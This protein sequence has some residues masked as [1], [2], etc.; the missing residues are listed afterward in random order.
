MSKIRTLYEKLS[1]HLI[2]SP[3]SI[4]MDTFDTIDAIYNQEFDIVDA[5][6]PFVNLLECTATHSAAAQNAANML[7]RRQYPMLAES[8]E[9]LFYHMSD[10]DHLDR[11]VIPVK[12]VKIWVAVPADQIRQY[13]VLDPMIGLKKVTLPADTQLTVDGYDFFLHW[14]VDIVVS[15]SDQLSARYDLSFTTP[16]SSRTSN[17]IE[18][19]TGHLQKQEYFFLYLEVD[20]LKVVS[21]KK[22]IS[23]ATG[24]SITTGYSD[25]FYYARVFSSVDGKVWSELKTTHTDQV[26]DPLVPTA[27]IQVGTGVVTVKIPEIYLSNNIVRGNM[28]IDIFT[29]RGKLKINFADYTESQWAV[30]WNDFG[31]LTRTWSEPLGKFSSFFVYGVERYAGGSD[32]LTFEQMKQKVVY[33]LYSKPAPFT[34]GELR[35]FLDAKNYRVSKQK[36]NIFGRVYVASSALPLPE[37]RD[38]SSSIGLINAPIEI[39][40]SRTDIVDSLKI[41]DG[42]VA[43]K[44]NVLFKGVS[45]G[46][47]LM[48]KTETENLDNLSLRAKSEELT[49]G[50][51]YYS[52]FHYILD[53]TEPAFNARAYYLPACREIARSYIANNNTLG[54]IVN[55]IKTEIIFNNADN[56]YQVLIDTQIPGN[57][58]NIHAVINYRDPTTGYNWD[59]IGVRS[60]VDSKTYRYAFDLTTELDI[61]KNHNF[62]MLGFTGPNDNKV[63]LNLLN[64]TFDLIYVIDGVGTSPFDSYLA[65]KALTQPVIGVV[66][67]RLIIRWGKHLDKLYIKSRPLITE[68]VY[69]RYTSDQQ[70]YYLEDI[71]EEGIAGNVLIPDGQGGLTYNFIHRAGDPM[72]EADGV[73]PVWLHRAGDII[74]D[75]VTDQPKVK[76]DSYIKHEVRFMLFDAAFYF[77]DTDEIVSYRNTIPD[78]ILEV[79]ESDIRNVQPAAAEETEIYYE[80]ISSSTSARVRIIEGREAVYRTAL[81][82]RL[83]VALNESAYGNAGIR[84]NIEK[85][86]R[87]KIAE[88]SESREITMLDVY[89]KMRQVAT[90]DIRN[91]TVESPFSNSD[92]AMLLDDNAKWS[93]A[94]QVVPLANGRLD[95]VDAIDIEW[96]K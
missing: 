2:V 1:G 4:A 57:N 24:A 84:E 52:M 58:E 13:A 47:R 62:T 19:R 80:P 78:Y 15:N 64:T 95:I 94:S 41:N 90:T 18:T 26:F 93:I 69:E 17:V 68:P 36:D 3:A 37:K 33:N 91:I 48:T 85:L 89:D 11:F 42:L 60:K 44:P 73:T 70:A 7:T 27:L 20:Q 10:M 51:Y 79:L 32:G 53:D 40:A 43:V 87:S 21:E 39:D 14:P 71:V 28:R 49:N 54:F 6:S 63:K 65:R 59:I 9:D 66:H 96:S 86:I 82:W 83:V 25:Q 34:E 12:N 76:K 30:R 46:Y 16:V 81:E 67:E 38:L 72:F 77:S 35:A 45:G 55:T 8:M 23:L 31:D 92:V 61:D 74:V 75:P 88:I 29:S 50:D 22:P 56:K 5:T